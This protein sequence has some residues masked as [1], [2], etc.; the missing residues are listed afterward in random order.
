MNQELR[1]L[2]KKLIGG[3]ITDIE[4]LDLFNGNIEIT[5]YFDKLLEATCREKI[6]MT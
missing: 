5:S 3:E 6:K 2:I 1:I 4:F